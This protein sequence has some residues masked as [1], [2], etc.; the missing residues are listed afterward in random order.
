MAVEAETKRDNIFIRAWR[1]FD[2]R[3]GTGK[4]VGG[5]ALHP[6]PEAGRLIVEGRVRGRIV[7]KIG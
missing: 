5:A 6:V 1:A 2:D 3:T 4:L 7:V